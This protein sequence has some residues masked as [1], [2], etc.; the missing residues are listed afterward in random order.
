M[1]SSMAACWQSL[2]NGNERGCGYRP[3]ADLVCTAYAL[4]RIA[5]VLQHHVIM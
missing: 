5:Q 1:G 4:R 3:L 2:T